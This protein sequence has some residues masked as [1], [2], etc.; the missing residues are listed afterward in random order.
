MNLT[1]CAGAF[2]AGNRISNIQQGMSNEEEKRKNS[3]DERKSEA[4]VACNSLNVGYS[5]LDI[6]Y[7]S[8]QE[9]Q[10]ICFS[11]LTIQIPILSS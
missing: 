7:S 6:G 10:I 8:F 5:L 3:E 11:P 1:G 2:L 4:V 9:S